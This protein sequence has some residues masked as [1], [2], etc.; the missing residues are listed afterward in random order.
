MEGP[1]LAIIILAGHLDESDRLTLDLF[2]VD[3]DGHAFRMGVSKFALRAVDSDRPL[4]NSD[5]HPVGDLDRFDS[6]T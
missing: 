4:V 3:R 5:F 6:D 1:I 2:V